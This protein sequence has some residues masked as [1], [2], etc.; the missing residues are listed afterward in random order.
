MCDELIVVERHRVALPKQPTT[1]LLLLLRRGVFS[2][3]MR[4][5]QLA[6]TSRTLQ[7]LIQIYG[8]HWLVDVE[9]CRW[10]V[11]ILIDSDW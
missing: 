10:L 2:M 9:E 6:L 3:R 7:V 5:T 8:D 1:G 11:F 4:V